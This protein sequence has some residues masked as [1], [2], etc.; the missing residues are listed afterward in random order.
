MVEPRIAEMSGHGVICFISNYSWLDGLSFAGMRESYLEK[1]DR[2]WIDCLNGDKYKTGKLTPDGRPDPSVFSTEWNLE[3]IQVGTAIGLLVRKRKP[4]SAD[5]IEFQHFWGNGKRED[6]LSSLGES[7]YVSLSP[8]PEMGLS[9]FPLKVSGRYNA[10]PNLTALFPAF[11]TGVKTSRD[12]LLVDFD[13]QALID[14]MESFFDP[15]VSFQDWDAQHPNLTEKTNRFDP[16]SVREQ[17]VRRGFLPKK[18]RKSTRLNSSHT[19]I[20]YAVFC[21]KKKKQK[22][23]ERLIANLDHTLLMRLIERFM[24]HEFFEMHKTCC[25]PSS[26]TDIFRPNGK[27]C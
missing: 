27:R 9:F 6:L 18:D 19:V 14:R 17:L 8:T 23:H 24:S 22:K 20:S 10:W 12:K 4:K 2:I 5:G 21:L 25:M 3:G 26:R 7:Q 15:A 11:F 16:Q 1:F 13:K